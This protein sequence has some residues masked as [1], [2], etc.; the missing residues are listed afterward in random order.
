[1]QIKSNTLGKL[2]KIRNGFVF[3]DKLVFIKE[4][5]QNCQR[6]KCDTVHFTITEN[7]LTISDNGCGCKRPES[8]FTLDLSD[9]DS[10]KEGYG[11]G[12]WSCLSIQN[13]NKIYVSSCN[14]KAIVDVN[15]LF[16]TED[17]Q[18]Q[19]ENQYLQKGYTVTLESS[20]FGLYLDEVIEYIKESSKLLEFTTY[21]NNV[22][23][24]KTT[25]FDDYHPR[26]YYKEYENS[27]FKAKICIS[28]SSFNS[29]TLFYDRREVKK[30]AAICDYI[31]GVIE[32]KLNKI[33]L[34]E[35]DRTSY[36]R[37]EKFYKVREK[38][39]ECAKDLYLSYI[40]EYGIENNDFSEG[41]M[42]FLNTSDY[43]KYLSLDIDEMIL[44]IQDTIEE[45]EKDKT[46]KIE[47]NIES[48]VESKTIERDEYVEEDNV[49]TNIYRVEPIIKYE[50]SRELPNYKNTLKQ[51]K[52]MMWCK[53]S[54]VEEYQKIIAEIQYCGIK[55]VTAKNILYENVFIKHNIPHITKINQCLKKTIIRKNVFIKNN[56]EELFIKLLEPIIQHYDL[57]YNI[58]K[59]ANLETLTIF[60]VD[61]KVLY[62]N[63]AINKKGIIETYGVTDHCYIYLDRTAL[64]LSKFKLKEGNIGIHELKA[65]M[66]AVNTI[67]HELAHYLKNTTDNTTEHYNAEIKIQQEIIELYL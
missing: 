44:S 7:Y 47:E 35:P 66:N 56:K 55:V 62:K 10:T 30:Y 29:L 37:D 16:E 3:D 34:K 15:K 24:E 46:N 6:S 33:T 18:V 28:N 57:P 5:L 67:A 61:G 13:L 26:T 51:L 4:L 45:T 8:V 25:I 53:A 23:V 38:L 22:E 21:I 14:W 52:K 2:K 12:F 19:L 40:K 60:E 32:V 58:F 48:I 27:L 64:N 1:M 9:W 50:T 49:H 63:K 11:I 65:I 31:E 36:I 42:N 39:T 41:I 54:E 20:F 43:E 17:L 59:I